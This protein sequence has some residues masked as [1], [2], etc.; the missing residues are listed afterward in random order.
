M[1]FRGY[2]GGCQYS[3]RDFN[4]IDW[5][6]AMES[7]AELDFSGRCEGF[8]ADKTRG[9]G[10]LQVMRHVRIVDT[11]RRDATDGIDSDRHVGPIASSG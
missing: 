2:A 11:T 4:T 9:N 7:S 5:L 6:S 3:I 10:H 8:A 1:Q